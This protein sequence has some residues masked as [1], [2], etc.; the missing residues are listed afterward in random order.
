M[1]EKYNEFNELI[2]YD[3]DLAEDFEGNDISHTFEH[4]DGNKLYREDIED[5]QDDYYLQL[6]RGNIKRIR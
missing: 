2:D 3:F 1:N 5:T 6:M 4:I